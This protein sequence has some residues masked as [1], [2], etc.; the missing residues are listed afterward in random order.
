MKG[1]RKS[2]RGRVEKD[3]GR[4]GKMR[5]RGGGG[6]VDEGERVR[7]MR[8][9][10]RGGEKEGRREKGVQRH[11]VISNRLRACTLTGR[12][13]AIT[14]ATMGHSPFITLTSVNRI[15]QTKVQ[16]Q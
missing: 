12:E 10:N 16:M 14:A 2:E 11:R 13:F 8:E 5:E 6:R 7:K 15:Q 4:K 1:K 9:R 3:R